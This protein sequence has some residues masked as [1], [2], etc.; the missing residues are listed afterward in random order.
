VSAWRLW[1]WT[2]LMRDVLT[3]GEVC[4]RLQLELECRRAGCSS[5][6]PGWL[7]F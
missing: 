4:E 7:P 2:M 3:L 1:A 5:H 6:P